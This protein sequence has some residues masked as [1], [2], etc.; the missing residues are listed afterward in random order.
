MVVFMPIGYQAKG[1]AVC[2]RH[3]A[4]AVSL[5]NNRW[6]SPSRPANE[7]GGLAPPEADAPWPREAAGLLIQL[8]SLAAVSLA[9]AVGITEGRGGARSTVLSSPRVSMPLARSRRLSSVRWPRSLKV[10]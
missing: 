6:Q 3:A 7:H 10:L 9:R 8:A 1:R 5:R 2:R 4:R